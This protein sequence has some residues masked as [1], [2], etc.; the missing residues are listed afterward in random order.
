MNTRIYISKDPR[1]DISTRE[2]NKQLQQLGINSSVKTYVSYDILNISEQE[3]SVAAASVFTEPVT[4]K[5]WF[6]CPQHQVLLGVE[7]L[8]GQFDI[9]ADAAMQCCRLLFNH[10]NISVRSF[11]L[12]GFDNLKPNELDL[13][14][15]HLINPVDSEEKNLTVLNDPTIAEPKAVHTIDGFIVF[16]SEE[17]TALI[18]NMRLSI[19]LADMLCIQDYFKSEN[20]NPTE[21]EIRALDTYW[22]D[23]CRHTTFLTALTDIKFEGDYAAEV[24]AVFEKYLSI[25]KTTGKENKPVSL[26]ELATTLPE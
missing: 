1:F 23:H 20:R 22:S 14:K 3:L 25:K 11:M 7:L 6:D 12:F 15:K 21:T 13:I 4:E 24:K 2:L 5:C 19:D 10:N 8:P 26:M 18:Q 9:R 16:T 17:L